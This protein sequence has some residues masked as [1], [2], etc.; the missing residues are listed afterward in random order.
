MKH[1]R[2]L[3]YVLRHKWFVLVECLRLGLLWRGLTHDLSKFSL[4]EWSP[5]VNHFCGSGDPRFDEAW[6]HHQKHNDH[7]W[8]YWVQ[9][10]DDGE[11]KILMMPL[12]AVLEMVCDWRGAGRA[13]G[14]GDDV[15]PWYLKNRDT[16]RLHPE[17]RLLVEQ[18][19]GLPCLVKSCCWT[20]KDKPGG[21]HKPSRY[22]CDLCRHWHDN[23]V[24]DRAID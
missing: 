4:M 6:L 21:P 12:S 24:K 19:L 7:H 9:L 15:V 2:Y 13:Q 18:L 20:S 3:R 23:R 5:Y 16:M 10:L 17:T 22:Y 11:K 8:Q 1:L 14:H